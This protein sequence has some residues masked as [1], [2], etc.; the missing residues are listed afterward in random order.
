MLS[1][2]QGINIHLLLTQI[3]LVDI[4][5]DVV[6]LGCWNGQSA[7]LIQKTLDLYDSQKKLHVYD[8]FEGLPE[9]HERDE[10]TYFKKGWCTT[11][12]ENLHRVFKTFDTRLPEIHPGWFNDTLADELPEKIA[13]AH[14]DGDFYTSIKESLDHTYHR[15]S[16]GAIVVIDDYCE[17][18]I[19]KNTVAQ[20]INNRYRREFEQRVIDKPNALPGVKSACDEFFQDKPEQVSAL[21]AGIAPHGFFR[22]Q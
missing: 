13:F 8:S 5:G 14:M 1:L 6:E 15:L 2:E 11:G 16:A 7:V 10:D 4:P 3:I 22:K 19:Q 18:D 12:Q 20:V 17:P 21:F 9:P